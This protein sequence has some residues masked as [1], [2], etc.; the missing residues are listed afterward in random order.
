[1]TT[2]GIHLT[3]CAG[4]SLTS[5]LRGRLT[6]DEYYIVSSF[7]ENLIAGRPQFWEIHKHS[8]LRFVFGHY[9]YELMVPLLA[10]K[11]NNDL[12][13]F[14]GM[15]N[16]I[17]RLLS[18]YHH[19]NR[20][21]SKR[22]T[23]EAFAAQYGSSMC[24][25][26]CRAFPSLTFHQRTKWENAVRILTCF[27]YVFSTERYQETIIPIYTKLG[28]NHDAKAVS[29]RENAKDESSDTDD[30]A[31]LRELLKTSDDVKVYRLSQLLIGRTNFG[32]RLA[33]DLGISS[34]REEW[35]HAMRSVGTGPE[36]MQRVFDY[37]QHMLVNE[38]LLLG[39]ETVTLA[40]ELMSDRAARLNGLAR[41]LTQR[42]LHRLTDH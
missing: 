17:E 36:V 21:S 8:A 29:S 23:P 42:G 31:A 22:I 12:F 7:W 2:L 27:D 15:R 33:S 3:K 4:T 9:V 35:Y 1:M 26:L 14:T 11:T 37:H 24:D 25:E 28:I 20:V 34:Q 41:C 5:D 40:V 13:V 19:L 38:L 30:D 32:M 39:E 10:P 18:Q 16:P 6:D